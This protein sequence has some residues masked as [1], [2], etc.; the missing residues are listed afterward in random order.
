MPWT[1][2]FQDDFAEEFSTFD[3]E[4]RKELR[5]MVGHLA[6]FGPQAKRPQVDT[7]KGSKIANLKEFRF[8]A[9]DGVWRVAFAF[10][11]KRRAIVLAAGDKSGVS[12]D[13]FY[14]R[15]I[16]TAEK[17]MAKFEAAQKAAKEARKKK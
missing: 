9:D 15:L 12:S 14:K 8:N 5:A 16:K 11:A 3:S 7:L 4:V 1:V 17:R 13:A 10:D 2:L 6:E